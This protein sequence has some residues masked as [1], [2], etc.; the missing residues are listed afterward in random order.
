MKSLSDIQN[1]KRE[2]EIKRLMKLNGYDVPEE[3]EEKLPEPVR[4][5]TETRR[6]AADKHPWLS[7]HSKALGFGLL[8]LALISFAAAVVIP[9][10]LIAKK[11]AADGYIP[12]QA[13]IDNKDPY[14]QNNSSNI[15]RI[16]HG[17]RT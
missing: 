2:K 10:F 11:S 7:D 1:E 6:S 4:Q 17:Y 5:K 15:Y 16:I 9:V 8:I 13:V 3:D 12:V 14:N